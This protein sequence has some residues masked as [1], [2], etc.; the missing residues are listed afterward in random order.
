[1]VLIVAL[2]LL[3]VFKTQALLVNDWIPLS[4]STYAMQRKE[5]E[6]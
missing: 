4:P 5:S 2:M 3:T 6:R 1:M